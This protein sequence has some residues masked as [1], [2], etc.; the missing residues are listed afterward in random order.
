MAHIWIF[1]V[2][3]ALLK[4]IQFRALAILSFDDSFANV[5]FCPKIRGSRIKPKMIALPIIVIV[6]PARYKYH[7]RDSFTASK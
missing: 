2:C 5:N 1:R 6:L 3:A 7:H 4:N